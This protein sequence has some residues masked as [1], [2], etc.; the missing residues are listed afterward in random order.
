MAERKPNSGEI[1]LG[2]LI[3]ALDELPWQTEEHE[4]MIFNA[5]GFRWQK[6]PPATPNPKRP[7]V[8]P[9]HI[10]TRRKPLPEKPQPPAFRAPP[11]PELPVEL[12][13]TALASSLIAL[14]PAPAGNSLPDWFD[15][16]GD[17][18]LLTAERHEAKPARISLFPALT[19]RGILGAA[20]KVKKTGKK[21]NIAALIAELT[22]GRVPQKLPFASDVTLEHG[23]RLLLDY[24]ESM[25]P[26]WEDLSAL[27]EQLENLLGEDKVKIYE[28]DRNPAKGEHWQAKGKTEPWRFDAGSPVLVASNLGIT[29]QSR[30]ISVSLEWRRFIAACR[31]NQ[32]PLLILVPWSRDYWPSGLGP[33][34]L[35][36]PWNPRTTAA[37]VALLVG[38][39]HEIGL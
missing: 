14:P 8:I 23:C 20:L 10:Y 3:R 34:P 13:K 36:I 7:N 28:F 12:P 21:I 15:D 11:I 29:G 26:F 32:L 27:A 25:T 33:H 39:G 18:D 31:K 38:K 24:S 6:K 2:E 17:A 4:R 5:L 16:A 37:E 22:K 35:L 1:G 9:E 19:Q 30:R